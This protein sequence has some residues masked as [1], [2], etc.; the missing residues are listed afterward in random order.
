MQEENVFMGSG[1]P[2]SKNDN[3]GGLEQAKAENEQEQQTLNDVEKDLENSKQEA[4][5]NDPMSAKNLAK[6]TGQ[7]GNTVRSALEF[8]RLLQ[9]LEWLRSL[10][11]MLATIVSNI[12]NMIVQ[13]IVG[14]VV[15]AVQGLVAITMGIASFLGISAIAAVVV[16]AGSFLLIGGFIV[17]MVFTLFTGVKYDDG[18]TDCGIDVKHRIELV[19]GASSPKTGMK[20]ETAKLIYSTFKEVGYSNTHIAGVLGNAETESGVDPTTIEGVYSEPFNYGPK[21]QEAYNDMKGWFERVLQPSYARAGISLNV[22]TYANGGDYSI[23]VGLFQLTGGREKMLRRFSQENGLLWYETKT[24]LAFALGPDVR[25][26][27]KVGD[28]NWVANYGSY[29]VNGPEQAAYDWA[30]N[31]EGNTSV[32]MDKRKR[33]AT[34]WYV[35]MNDWE[36]NKEFAISVLELAKTA[37]V[38]AGEQGVYNSLRDCL[39]QQHYDNSSIA[40]AILSYAWDSHAEGINN[41][42]TPLYQRLKEQIFPGDYYNQSCD[43]SVAVGIRWSGADDAFPAGAVRHQLR[44]MEQSD[45]W[46]EIHWGGDESLLQPGDILIRDDDEV[47][48]VMAWIGKELVQQ[49]KPGNKGVL[50]HGSIGDYVGANTLDGKHNVPGLSRSP[51]LTPAGGTA[52]TTYR[53][54]RN[55]QKETNSKYDHLNASHNYEGN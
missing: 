42:G 52:H 54:F 55:V 39:T 24:Q 49:R 30:L 20:L 10:V 25:G 37:K 15:G 29:P 1:K 53:L 19:D 47:G 16:S 22:A 34:E 45:K 5:K 32:H 46:V 9:I 41:N 33:L 8:L 23:G 26:V 14:W 12:F 4:E 17:A 27:N 48:H 51:T 18:L 3:K 2:D 31:Y 28:A 6:R 11:Q 38:S 35:E 36:V 7:V 44:H 43:R 40:T 21:S 50:V 13:A